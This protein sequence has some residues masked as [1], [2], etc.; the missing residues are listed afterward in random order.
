MH[1]NQK[2]S[3]NAPQVQHTF[4]DVQ[5]SA[6]EPHFQS[7]VVGGP[8]HEEVALPIFQADVP[9]LD[10]LPSVTGWDCS[11]PLNLTVS[12]ASG[13]YATTAAATSEIN[14]KKC[15]TRA[16]DNF[17]LLGTPGILRSKGGQLL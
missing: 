12:D 8:N 13:R 16:E 15:V 4:V 10:V 9:D 11:D 7:S 6:I 5:N 17:F 2:S 3:V 14:S 1:C